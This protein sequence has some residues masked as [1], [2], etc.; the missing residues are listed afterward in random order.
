MTCFLGPVVQASMVACVASG[1]EHFES[2]RYTF[3]RYPD[4]KALFSTSCVAAAMAGS[5]MVMRSPKPPLYGLITTIFMSS[6]VVRA[7]FA[8]TVT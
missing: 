1:T 5:T 8:A 7:G 2:P 4:N 6:T 3:N